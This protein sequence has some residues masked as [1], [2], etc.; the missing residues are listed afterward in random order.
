[1]IR[2]ERYEYLYGY[3][4]AQI[5][6]MMYDAP[7][8]KYKKDRDNEPKPGEKGFKRT[9]E[10]AQ[11]AYDDWKKRYEADKKKG[12]KYDLGALMLNGEKKEIKP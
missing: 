2:V 9:A 1:M 11:K 12:I 10:Q 4:A 5:E 6:M 8:V 7:V 3:T